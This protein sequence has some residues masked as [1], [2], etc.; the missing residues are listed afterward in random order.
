MAKPIQKWVVKNLF[1]AS[2]T[3][4][5]L[6]DRRLYNYLLRN[7]FNR[8]LKQASFKIL[9]TDL[10]GV[11]GAGVPSLER[12]KESFRR[13]IRTLIEYEVD[14]KWIITSLLEK[15]ELDEKSAQVI[16]SYP[17]ECKR[18]FYDPFIL[19]KCLIQAHFI[20][21]YSNLLYEILATAHYA[22]ESTLFLEITD[23]RSRLH[24]QEGKLINFNDLDRFAL[25]PAIKEINSYASFAV[26]YHTQRKGMKVIGITFE[27]H[28]KREISNVENI[29]PAKHPRLFIDN[30][31]MERAYAYLLNAETNE[32]RK[33]FDLACK[34]AGKKK[35]KIAEEEFDRPDLWFKWV[36]H[37]LIKKING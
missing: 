31:E 28:S 20:Q 34:M 37:Q 17:A 23:L 19:E 8:F 5:T 14:E 24:I 3:P 33:F 13:L 7:A 6:A 4:L 29:I 26:K 25:T 15:A 36:E 2:S 30:P 18:L 21:K 16:Y 9:L 10:I 11:Y 22:K 27:M 12:L 32:R 35:E 1:L